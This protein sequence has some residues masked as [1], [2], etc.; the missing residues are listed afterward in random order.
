MADSKYKSAYAAMAEHAGK[1]LEE[2]IEMRYDIV[3][4]QLDDASSDSGAS[5]RELRDEM[6]A[7][8]EGPPKEL[9]HGSTERTAWFGTWLKENCQNDDDMSDP[10][11]Y[12]Q[13]MM[14][15]R[16]ER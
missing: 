6:S 12:V 15:A 7:F 13:Q 1:S 14:A 9:A 8:D 4:K 2:C 3:K 5:S 10:M 11:Q 16:D